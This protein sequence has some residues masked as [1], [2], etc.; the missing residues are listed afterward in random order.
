MRVRLADGTLVK[1][2]VVKDD[3]PVA[4]LLTLSDVMGTGRSRVAGAWRYSDV[5]ITR[6]ILEFVSRDGHAARDA[7]DAYWG[8]RVARLGPLEGLR[9]AEEL[10]RQAQLRDPTW[11]GGPPSGSALPRAP[12]RAPPSCR[13]SPPHLSC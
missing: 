13:S 7:K 4:A 1:L 2:P 5:V 12:G 8:E 10:R 9:I 3:A 11:P 6:G